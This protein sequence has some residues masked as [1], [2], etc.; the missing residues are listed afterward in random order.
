MTEGVD[1]NA[2][3]TDALWEAVTGKPGTQDWY[4]TVRVIDRGEQAEAE[5]RAENHRV[6]GARRGRA[7]QA[8]REPATDKQTTYLNTLVSQV[9]R[10]RFGTGVASRS[11]EEPAQAALVRLTKAQP[12]S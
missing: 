11:A 1:G 3:T 12:A 2:L 5:R 7:A 9:G 10:E 6:Y 8:K 4:E